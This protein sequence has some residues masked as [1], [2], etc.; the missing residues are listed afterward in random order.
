[1]K[2]TPTPEDLAELGYAPDELLT[3]HQLKAYSRLVPEATE[4]STL[5]VRVNSLNGLVY[6]EV[7]RPGRHEEVWP[8]YP[9]PTKLFFEQLLRA[10]GWPLGPALV[11]ENSGKLPLTKT[12]K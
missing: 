1:M 5:V 12:T 3:F 9:L 2:Y 7:H 4:L 8:C 10:I 6:L 11:P